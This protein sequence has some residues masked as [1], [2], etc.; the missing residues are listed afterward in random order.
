MVTTTVTMVTSTIL[1]SIT[2]VPITMYKEMSTP[3]IVTR[4]R[5]TGTMA[6]H[7]TM[8]TTNVITMATTIVRTNKVVV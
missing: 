5:V 3:D 6:G 8:V 1:T 4:T 7:I 2:L